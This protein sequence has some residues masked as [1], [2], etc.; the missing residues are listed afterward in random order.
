L[1]GGNLSSTSVVSLVYYFVNNATNATYQLQ[2]YD[3]AYTKCL[4]VE[5]Q[6]IGADIAG[7]VLY[8]KYMS[9]FNLGTIRRERCHSFELPPRM[10]ARATGSPKLIFIRK[11]VSANPS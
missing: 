3:G 11:P 10:A 4:K 5:L 8:A 6:Q 9:G 2:C 1:G 7:R